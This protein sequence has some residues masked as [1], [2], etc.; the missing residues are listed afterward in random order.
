MVIALFLKPA[1]PHSGLEWHSSW[2]L[3]VCFGF[4]IKCPTRWMFGHCSLGPFDVNFG[5]VNFRRSTPVDWGH[6]GMPLKMKSLICPV[7]PIHQDVKTLQGHTHSCYY[8]GLSLIFVLNDSIFTDLTVYHE[9]SILGWSWAYCV[10]LGSRVCV[11]P[12]SKASMNSDSSGDPRYFW[13]LAWHLNRSPH[14]GYS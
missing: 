2:N 4:N 13:V 7:S 9:H 3:G 14:S 11:K 6:S 8:D 10:L 5:G 12:S 1:S